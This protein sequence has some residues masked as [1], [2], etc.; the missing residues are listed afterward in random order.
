MAAVI[1]SGLVV[2]LWAQIPERKPWTSDLEKAVKARWMG[3]SES[4]VTEKL[5]PPEDRRTQ[6][7]NAYVTWKNM[8]TFGSGRSFTCQALFTFASD[9]MTGLEIIGEDQGLCT[10]LVYPLVSEPPPKHS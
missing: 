1:L 8:V 9:Q 6:D 4:A 7:K 2:P 3:K 10:K 5:G